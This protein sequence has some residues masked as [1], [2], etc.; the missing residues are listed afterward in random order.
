MWVLIGVPEPAL[1]VEPPLPPVS[2]LL[3]R[4][5][6]GRVREQTHAATH[7][8]FCTSPGVIS[9]KTLNLAD[10]RGCT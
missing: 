6:E 8:R 1:G 7:S 5:Q 2:V 10:V 3:A 4:N 9:L